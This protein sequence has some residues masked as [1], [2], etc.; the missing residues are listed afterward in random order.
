MF[1]EVN[2]TFYCLCYTDL[3]QYDVYMFIEVNNTFYCLCYT[4]LKQY[5]V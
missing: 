4:D 5:N 3:K 1:I 2:N